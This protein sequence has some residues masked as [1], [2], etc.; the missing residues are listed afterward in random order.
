MRSWPWDLIAIMVLAALLRLVL[1]DLKAPHFDEGV[2]GWFADRLRETGT[3]AYTP[4][5]F[6]GPWH[7]YTVFLSQEL[8]G[9]NLWALRLPVVLA[10][11]LCLPVFFCSPAGSDAKRCAGRRSPLPSRPRVFF[12]EGIRF[13]NRG[14]SFSP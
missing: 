6:H 4:D 3:F 12:T 11:L 7:F 14:S 8:L 2:N 5:N 9:R 1:L 10:S 13:T